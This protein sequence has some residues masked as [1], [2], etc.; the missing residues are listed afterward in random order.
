M[1]GKAK[2]SVNQRVISALAEQVECYR[3]L[4]KLAALQHVHVQQGQTEQ[5]LEVLKSRQEVLDRVA[6]FESVIAPAKRS[7]ERIC[8]AA[9]RGFAKQGRVS[10]GRDAPASRAD[11]NRRP[12]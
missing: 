9:G 7:L 12:Q 6:G 2:E 3:R 11:H 5:L 1:S 4:A 10:T 8:F